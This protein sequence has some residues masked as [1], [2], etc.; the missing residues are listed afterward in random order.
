MS[1]EGQR[2][3]A[4]CYDMLTAMSD[5]MAIGHRVDRGEVQ[6]DQL[7]TIDR[8]V[9]RAATLDYVVHGKVSPAVASI[10]GLKVRR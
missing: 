3:L 1:N 4:E 10:T 2:I 6:V 7:P 5:K 9:S 8:Y